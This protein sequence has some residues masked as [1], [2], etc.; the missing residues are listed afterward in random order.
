MVG[1]EEKNLIILHAT[2][3]FGGGVGTVIRNLVE[4]QLGLGC[5]VGIIYPKWE[6]NFNK[7]NGFGCNVEKYPVD[8]IRV[9]GL[10]QI[11]GLPLMKLYNDLKIKNKKSQIILHAHNP[12]SVGLFRNIANLPLICTIHGVNTVDSGSSQLITNRILLRLMR[13]NHCMVAVS[14]DVSNHYNRVLGQVYIK[15]ILNG[16]KIEPIRNQYSFEKFT[17]GYI[18]DLNELKGWRL[19][20]EAY[21]LLDTSYKNKIN[22]VLA[23]GGDQIEEFNN[24][25]SSRKLDEN[26]KYLGVVDNAGDTLIPNL[27]LVILPSK[28][29]GLGLVLIEALANK[30][31]ILATKVGGIP[32]VLIEGKNGFFVE[33]NP[34]DIARKIVELYEDKALYRNL[35]KNA[36]D[37]Y[38]QKFTLEKMGDS[39]LDLYKGIENTNGKREG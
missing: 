18:A 2:I 33:R 4:Y 13:A 31:P 3:G 15:C 25:V 29:E 10:N 37:T 20:V 6:R 12:V 23:G 9:K 14:N 26:I 30:V 17:I 1:I 35:S 32:E 5:R 39:Y 7:L 27:D 8:V 38:N 19:L 16:V 34:E 36:W 21:S 11:Q 28:S 24:F 22:L